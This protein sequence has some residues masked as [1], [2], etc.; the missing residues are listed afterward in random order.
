MRQ[1]LGQLS[2]SLYSCDLDLLGKFSW[3]GQRFICS[4]Q[5]V[6]CFVEFF[7]SSLDKKLTFLL[8]INVGWFYSQMHFCSNHTMR[9]V[10][11][12]IGESTVSTHACHNIGKLRDAVLETLIFLPTTTKNC[13][14]N[15]NVNICVSQNKTWIHLMVI[16]WFLLFFPFF[17]RDIDWVYHHLLY[18]KST[19]MLLSNPVSRLQK[20]ESFSTYP[21]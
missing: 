1:G 4:L 20:Y 9:T 2:R 21:N 15:I 18:L 3:P 7:R 19:F 6:R 12:Y 8:L 10:N 17:L 5:N 16:I 13:S 11:V 14:C